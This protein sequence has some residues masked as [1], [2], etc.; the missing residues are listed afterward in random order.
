MITF[1]MVPKGDS[2]GQPLS[3]RIDCCYQALG[4]FVRRAPQSAGT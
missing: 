3:G 2:T 4:E 1:I